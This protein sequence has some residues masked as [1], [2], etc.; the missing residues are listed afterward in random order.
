MQD[1]DNREEYS[2]SLEAEHQAVDVITQIPV[3]QFKIV[4]HSENLFRDKEGD[5]RF[6]NKLGKSENATPGSLAAKLAT[7]LP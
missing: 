6:I 7:A 4:K 2:L 5:F 3:Q 1:R